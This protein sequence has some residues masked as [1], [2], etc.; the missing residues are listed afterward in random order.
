M[1]TVPIITLTRHRHK[2]TELIYP[3]ALFND[4]SSH[5]KPRL[6]KE[7]SHSIQGVCALIGTLRQGRKASG[8]NFR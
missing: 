8:S 2:P 4:E 7:V 5:Y 1:S 6:F 3:E